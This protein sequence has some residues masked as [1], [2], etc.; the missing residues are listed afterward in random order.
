MAEMRN[1]FQNN[2]SALVMAEMRNWF[3]NNE[4]ASSVI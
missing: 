4:S 1:W 2:E 3:Q